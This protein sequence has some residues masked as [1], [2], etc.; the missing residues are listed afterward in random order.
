MSIVERRVLRAE[1]LKMRD[2]CVSQRHGAVLGVC[3]LA[4]VA[5]LAGGGLPTVAAEQRRPAVKIESVQKHSVNAF[6][7]YGDGLDYTGEQCAFSLGR[8]FYCLHSL[9]QSGQLC[10]YPLAGG[11]VKRL[12]IP[13]PK[14]F[15][16]KYD[17]VSYFGD[18][19]LWADSHGNLLLRWNIE[20]NGGHG[21]ALLQKDSGAF[22]MTRCAMALANS[23][24]VVAADGA[25]HLLVWNTK[26]PGSFEL[27]VFRLDDKLTLAPLGQYR[28]A[29]HH[30]I[31]IL[32]ACFVSQDVLHVF[33]AEVTDGLSRASG[34]PGW[35]RAI[36]AGVRGHATDDG[37]SNYLRLH[38]VD[39]NVR[40]K[41]WS[42]E[43]EIYRL[44]KFVSSASGPAVLSLEDKSRH[45]LWKVE[46]ND[47]GAKDN[48]LY[49]QS[50]TGGKPQKLSSSHDGFKAIAVGTRIVVCY[51]L[52]SEP[53]KVIFRVIQDAT[54]GPVAAITIAGGRK[55]NVW[56]KY[57]QLGSG[58]DRVWFVNT[59][60][61]NTLYELRIV[62]AK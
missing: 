57:L 18:P 59:L 47:R 14:G 22:V 23:R 24:A 12:A 45:Y 36:W 41:S 32:D 31:D 11:P 1:E 33:Y 9:R 39:F 46:T 26:P 62:E 29:G 51:T 16:P 10:S 27:S 60:D 42:N 21:L 17:F 61:I 6:P 53:N 13:Q 44:D 49:Y 5:M 20:G 4:G 34:W 19:A 30:D 43:R 15:A 7:K 50:T 58:P 55:S 28:G 3:F 40:Q 8:L 38:T 54:P 56:G 37:P 2:A 52:E 25:W 35:L 48:G